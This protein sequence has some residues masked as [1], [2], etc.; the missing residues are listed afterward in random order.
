[1]QLNQFTDFALRVLMYCALNGGRVARTSEIANAYGI[2]E[3][4]LTKVAQQLAAD[5]Y[6]V[7]LR[8]R[9][10]GLRLARAPE[11]IVIG[12]VV[13]KMEVS[14]RLAEC[15]CPKTNTCPIAP[16]CRFRHALERALAAFFLVLDGYTLGDLVAMPSALQPLLRLDRPAA[17]E[18]QDVASM[19]VRSLATARSGVSP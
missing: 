3:N 1:M 17:A 8:G 7:T 5:G 15:F 12:E 10:G 6:I 11:D 16:A 9:G 13:R 2:S 4:H 18:P 14:L 19:S